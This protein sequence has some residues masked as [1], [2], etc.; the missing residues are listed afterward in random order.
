[1]RDPSTPESGSASGLPEP[2]IGP[3]FDAAFFASVFGERVRT[4]CTPRPGDVPVVEIRLADGA[5]L[6]LCHIEGLGRDWLAAQGYR[7]TQTC[8]EMDLVL[9]PYGLITPITISSWNPH[10]RRIGFDLERS[11]PAIGGAGDGD[12]A[13]VPS[14]PP[15]K[16]PGE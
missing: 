13:P 10:Q 5:V 12:A 2:H 15:V 11:R 14:G 16:P 7:D 8:D 6:D 9:V 4:Q 1:M 3:P